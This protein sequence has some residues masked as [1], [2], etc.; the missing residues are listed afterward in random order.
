MSSGLICYGALKKPGVDIDLDA[1]K[2]ML[3]K[4]TYADVDPTFRETMEMMF[5]YDPDDSFEL[6][7]KLSSEVIGQMDG[8]LEAF[9]ELLSSQ[10]TGWFGLFGTELYF[11]AEI[12]MGD[13][14]DGYDLFAAANGIPKVTEALGFYSEWPDHV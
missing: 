9:V 6:D 5:D 13:S 11:V 14:P 4:I 1:A 8:L 3:R 2:N 7:Q 10:T 12:T